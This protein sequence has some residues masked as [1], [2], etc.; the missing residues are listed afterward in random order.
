MS[1]VERWLFS[2]LCSA[3]LQLG[4]PLTSSAGTPKRLSSQEIASAVTSRLS[5]TSQFYH[6][7]VRTASGDADTKGSLCF[8]QPQ[9]CWVEEFGDQPLSNPFVSN[10]FLGFDERGD[11]IPTR[12]L[13]EKFCQERRDVDPPDS[14]RDTDDES[15][16]DEPPDDES[17]DDSSSS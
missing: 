2:V 3:P 17:P 15:P 16:D 14:M 1:A 4:F 13:R 7:V 8:L 6:N 12:A 9:K 10:L 5:G 11:L